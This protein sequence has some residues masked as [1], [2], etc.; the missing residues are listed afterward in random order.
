MTLFTPT[1]LKKWLHYAD[2]SDF[3][4][5][6]AALAEQV[7]AG[8]LCDA[9]DVEDLAPLGDEVL[10]SDRFKAWAI[11]LGGIAYE[12]PT[13]MSADAAAEINSQWQID[14]R[15]QILDNVR[16]WASTRPGYTST[17]PRPRGCFPPPR[18]FPGDRIRHF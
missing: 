8:W 2:E 17:V 14:R 16:T 15:R 10:G 9:I 18:P 11:E 7:V 12:N 6:E 5:D 13:S 1:E 3:S 4:E